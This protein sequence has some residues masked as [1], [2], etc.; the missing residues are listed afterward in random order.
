MTEQVGAIQDHPDSCWACM[1]QLAC[2]SRPVQVE[3]SPSQSANLLLLAEA[4]LSLS[5]WTWEV[6]V[7][8]TW[9]KPS[10]PASP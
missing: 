5:L 4:D 10:L 1:G 7:C 8:F 9:R 2:P 3:M 6:V